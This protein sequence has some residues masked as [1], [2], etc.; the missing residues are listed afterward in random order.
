MNRAL[1]FL[2]GLI[3]YSLSAHLFAL[4]TSCCLLSHICLSFVYCARACARGLSDSHSDFRTGPVSTVDCCS[5]FRCLLHYSN[6]Y[7]IAH[8]CRTCFLFSTHDYIIY[9]VVLIPLPSL[10]LLLLLILY[11]LFNTRSLYH[12]V[13]LPVCYCHP[14]P[15]LAPADRH[16]HYPAHLARSPFFVLCASRSDIYVYTT[17]VTLLL[18]ISFLERPQTFLSLPL[19]LSL[20]IRSFPLLLSKCSMFNHS[21]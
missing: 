16:S 10:L 11:S 17:L 7:H 9:A 15:S 5:S 14:I 4:Y 13:Y 21:F 12:T 20:D 19:S 6:P 1:V 18:V 8:Y 2:N 3:S